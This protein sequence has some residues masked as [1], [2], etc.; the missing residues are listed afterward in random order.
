MTLK[1]VLIGIGIAA[2]VLSIVSFAVLNVN[3][4]GEE[5][6]SFESTYQ[7]DEVTLKATIWEN[8]EAEYAVL[9]CPGYSCDRQKWRPLAN[10]FTSNGM[11]VMSFDYSGQGGSYGTIGFDN[12]KTDDIAVEIADAI[13]VLH[14]RTG[15]DYDHIILVGH[16]MGGRSILRLLQD[17]NNPDAVT[18]VTKRNIENVILI[19]PEVN[20]FANAQASLFA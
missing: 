17:Y 5:T 10:L 14:D 6:F 3:T 19:A 8:D 16:S 13:E 7:G 9:I 20:Y 2:I 4:M 12:A 1:R 18:T 15:I 11:T